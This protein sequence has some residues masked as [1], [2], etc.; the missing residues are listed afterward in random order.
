MSGALAGQRVGVLGLARSGLAAARLALAQGAQVYA[1]D[2]A[3]SAATREAADLVRE[4]GGEAESGGH[5]LERLAACD[6][7]VLSPGIPPDVP[8]LREP[9]LAGVP[10]VAE[11]EF[12]YRFLEAPII[13][14]TGTNGKTT[15]TAL[16]SHLLQ[17]AGIDA[18]AGGNIGVALSELALRDPPPQLAVVE[19]SSFQLG[20]IRDFAPSIGVVTNLAPDHLDRYPSLRAYYADKARLFLNATRASRW[21]LNGEDEEV[22]AL[23]RDAPGERYLFRVASEP[24]PDE[25]GGYLSS[26]RTLVLRLDDAGEERLLPAA[27]LSLLGPHNVANA[28]AAAIAARLAGADAEAI[29]RGLRSF[30]A[31]PHRL[32]PVAERGGVLWINDSKA[33]NIAST[34]VALRS[35]DRPTLLLLG[36][37]HKGEPYTE[38][39]PELRERVR[40]VLAFGEAEEQVAKDLEPYLAVERVPGSFDEV[41]RRAAEL[42]RPGDAVLLS[43]ACSSYDMFDNFEERGRRFAELAARVNA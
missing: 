39:L 40:C 5:D 41:V 9:A 8:L 37:R 34:R 28:L 7:I 17:Q 10:V 43:P 13:A 12:A 36:G 21:V 20:G 26:E 4:L 16:I 32:E 42:A 3:V 6:L 31:P 14:V 30:R 1:S 35:M 27:E 24:G 22:L 23:P 11:V 29:V 15:T 38:L 25:R 33:T 19:V 2:A 18:P